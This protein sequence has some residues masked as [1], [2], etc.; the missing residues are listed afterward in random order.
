MRTPLPLGLASGLAA[1]LLLT[2]CG[3]DDGDSATTEGGDGGAEAAGLELVNEGTLTVCSDIPYAPFE[4]EDADAPSGFT[5]FDID[6]MQEIADRLGL[7]L[8]VQI[9]GFD[10]IESGTALAADQC[11]LAASAMTITEEREENLDFSDPY[12]DSLQSLL[13]SSESGIS[14]LDEFEGRNLGVQGATTGE[15]Y[16]QENA[17]EGTEIIAYEDDGL[18][19]QALQAGNIDGILQDLPVNVEHAKEEGYEIVEEFDTGEQYGFAVKEEGKE[20]LLEEINAQLAE[21][22]DDGTYDEIYNRYFATD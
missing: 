13:V 18:L 6:L 12:Y 9:T 17:P 11:D 5:G 8:S 10:A 14:S 19:W 1:V 21:L 4:F 16:A 2:A 22:R 15:A 20:A 7:E 3:D